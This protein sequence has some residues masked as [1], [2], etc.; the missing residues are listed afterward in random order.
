[1]TTSRLIAIIG[2]FIGTT[3]AW[4]VLGVTLSVRSSSVG[5]HL[6][7]EVRKVWGPGLAQPH[8]TVLAD[9]TASGG[10]AETLLPAT[11][12]VDVKLHYDPQKRGLLWH[13]TYDVELRAQ[14]EIVNASTS[15]RNVRVQ[16]RLPS[17]ETSY[18][19]F[20]FQLGEGGGKEVTPHEGVIEAATMIPAGATL[21]LTVAYKAR[22]LDRWAYSFAEGSRVK[23]FT[24]TMAADFDDISFPIGA[25]SPSSRTPGKAG[26]WDLVWDYKDVID[27]RDIAMDM[28]HLLNAGPVIA[29]ITFFAPVSLFFFMAVLVIAG[30]LRG[31]NLHPM[32]HALLAA[33]FFSFHLLLAYLG[34]L[35]PLHVGFIVA[36]LVSLGLVCGY[37]RAVAGKPFALIA[38]AAQGAYMIL[39]SYSF[40]FEGYTGL[41]LTITGVTTLAMLMFATAGVNW[42]QLFQSAGWSWKKKAA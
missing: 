30:M 41:T 33:G 24:L 18:D 38:L 4:F 22:G 16:L 35:M 23:N 26:G 42:E 12:R 9:T 19:N 11:S 3:A 32:T 7:D 29:R 25:T 8:L 6:G 27:A 10:A 34:D 2:I 13:R 37:I 14:Y 28:P 31:V 1:M 15:P 39:F 40:F 20:T 21:P 17:K 5:R 36:A